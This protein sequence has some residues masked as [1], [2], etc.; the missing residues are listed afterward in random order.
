M[1]KLGSAGRPG[2]GS[3]L[4]ADPVSQNVALNEAAHASE[5]RSL[6]ALKEYQDYESNGNGSNGN[7]SNGHGSNGHGANGNG[8]NGN[9][10]NGNG[11]NG[12]SS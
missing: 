6:T 10:A 7:G 3:F 5:Q 8:A 1:N 4:T 9:G 12:H 2:R 11:A